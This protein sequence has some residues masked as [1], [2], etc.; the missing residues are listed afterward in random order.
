MHKFN[1]FYLLYLKMFVT[2]LFPFLILLNTILIKSISISYRQSAPQKRNVD[3]RYENDLRPLLNEL[4]SC[5]IRA[6]SIQYLLHCVWC[7]VAWMLSASPTIRSSSNLYRFQTLVQLVHR[8][9]ILKCYTVPSKCTYINF[10]SSSQV[11]YKYVP[12][13][14]KNT[15][16]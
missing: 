4:H 5:V 2:V 15:L 16:I 14:M 1:F 12:R 11:W 8:V 13:A 9:F 3:I 10:F 7:T 6:A